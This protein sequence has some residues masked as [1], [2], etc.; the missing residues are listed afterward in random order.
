MM[1]APLLR[2]DWLEIVDGE[3]LELRSPPTFLRG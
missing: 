3:R 2:W 1:K